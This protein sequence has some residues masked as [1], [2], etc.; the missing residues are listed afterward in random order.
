MDVVGSTDHDSSVG[1]DHLEPSKS[2]TSYC[3]KLTET[4]A[5]NSISQVRVVHLICT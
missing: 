3:S 4:A 2:T 1:E 5:S